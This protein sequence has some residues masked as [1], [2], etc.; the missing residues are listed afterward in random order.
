M[1]NFDKIITEQFSN[2]ILLYR[3]YIDDIFIL[4]QPEIIND[5][6]PFVNSINKSLQFTLEMETNNCLPFLDIYI[7]RLVDNN[8]TYLHT[9]VY[10]KPSSTGQYINFSSAAPL[11][12]KITVI[13]SLLHRAFLYCSQ[14]ITLSNEIKKIFSDLKNNGFPSKLIKKY[15]QLYRFKNMYT[16]HP[17]V[18][19][20]PLSSTTRQTYV[21]IPYHKFLSE[22]ISKFLKQ[23]NICTSFKTGFNIKRILGNQTHPPLPP[24][25]H[26]GIVYRINCKGCDGAYIGET[27]RTG[28]TRIKEHIRNLKYRDLNSKLINHATLTGHPPDFDNVKVLELNINNL[29]QRRFLEGLHTTNQKNPLNDACAIAKEYLLLTPDLRDHTL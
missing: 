19:L 5:I 26:T 24:L 6:L 14:P 2:E 3:R 18:S 10:R 12:H 28:S 11:S 1:Q 17:S 23:Y 7:Q 21:S 22:K 29:K 27:G 25:E 16:P 8:H 13:H 15:V 9:S 20:I 4:A